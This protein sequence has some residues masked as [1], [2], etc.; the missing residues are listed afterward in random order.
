MAWH[1]PPCQTRRHLPGCSFSSG[2]ARNC[3]NETPQSTFES[4][5]RQLTT[6]PAARQVRERTH[7]WVAVRSNLSRND[8][9][10]RRPSRSCSSI[11]EPN[12]TAK[13]HEIPCRPFHGGHLYRKLDILTV[14]N[15]HSWCYGD[16]SSRD[17]FV[18]HCVCVTRLVTAE[19]SNL[20]GHS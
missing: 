19:G 1:S 17:G 13:V 10:L 11:F 14:T 18:T 2:G 20:A 3:G 9:P 12:I 5:V 4:K 8:R 15:P 16:P 7:G 6:H